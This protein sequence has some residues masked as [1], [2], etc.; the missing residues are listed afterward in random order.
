M[1]QVVLS[2]FWTTLSGRSLDDLVWVSH[3]QL[4]LDFQLATGHRGPIHD[5]KWRDGNLVEMISLSKF[6]FR[7][8][9]RWFTKLLKECLHHAGQ[10]FVCNYCVPASSVLQFH[11]GTIALPWPRWRLDAV[12]SWI[13][14]RMPCGIRR[15]GE[16]LDSLPFAQRLVDFPSFDLLSG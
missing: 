13:L 10:R 5:G 2:W 1:V 3:P 6:A 15:S 9:A 4:Y 8:R 11:T 12:D 16:G 14:R 7:T